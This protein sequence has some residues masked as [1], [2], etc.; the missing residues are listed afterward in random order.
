MEVDEAAGEYR[1]RYK[2]RERGRQLAMEQS[3][4]ETLHR[5]QHAAPHQQRHWAPGQWVYV[6]RRARANKGLHLRDRWVGPGIVV[7]SNNNTVYV[8]MRSR[9]WRCATEQLRPALSSEILGK[10]LT[11]DPGLA[12]LLRQVIAGTRA[13]A[14]DVAREGPPPATAR[15]GPVEH[16]PDGVQL[17][18]SNELRLPS[19]E[20][21]QHQAPQVVPAVPPGLLAPGLPPDAAAVRTPTPSPLAHEV[22]VPPDHPDDESE[23]RTSRRSSLQEPF[24]EPDA[25]AAEML[26][27]PGLESIVEEEEEVMSGGE[28]PEPPPKVP[29]LEISSSETSDPAISTSQAASSSTNPTDQVEPGTRA[30]GT[31]IRQLMDRVIR[32]QITPA[33]LLL[34]ENRVETLSEEFDE[35]TR[36]NVGW[37]G[38]YFNYSLGDQVL[39]PQPDGLWTLLAKRNDEISLK[40]LSMEER[41]LFE[42]SDKIEWEAILKTKAVRVVTGAEAEK[43]RKLYPDRIMSS[44]MVRRKK[45]QPGL[46]AWKAKSRWCIHG[47]CDPDTGTLVTYAPTPQSEG[48]MLFHQVALNHQMRFA[49]TDVRNAFCQS[50]P[51]RRPRGPLFAEPCEGLGLPPGSLICIDIPVYGLDDAPASWRM[52]VASFLVEDLGF[53]RNIVEPCWYSL[54]QEGQ[55]IA[56][57]LVEVD[58]FVI[59]AIPSYYPSLKK[60]M[61]ARF[62][63][64]K[65][66]ENSAEYAGRRI[67]CYDEFILVDQSKYIQEQVFPISLARGRRQQSGESLTAEEFTSLRSLIYKINWLA[68]ETRPE[69]AGLASIMASKLKSAR[70]GDILTVNKFV[71]FLRSTAERPLKIWR[72][73]P[74]DMCF[75]VCSDAGGINTK[76]AEILDEEG[77]PSDATQGAWMVLSAAHLPHGQQQVKAS[78]MA[79]RSSKLRRKV[80]STYGGETQAMLQGVNEVDWLQVMYRDA[81]AHDVQL[82]TWRSSL[83]PHMLV[84]RGQCELGGRQQQCSVTDAKSLF[85]CLLREHPTGKQDRKSALE[86]AIVLRDLQETKSM[87]R[88]VP[89]QKMIVDCLTHE[90]PL[91]AN[92]A[93]NQLLRTGILSLVDVAQ[94]LASRKLD[95]MYRRRSHAASRE[96]LLGKYRESFVQWT[97][98]LVNDI[99]G[100]CGKLTHEND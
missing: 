14:V 61:Q 31:P 26:E 84:M 71:N 92:D 51:L 9:L 46:H 90:D 80:F 1:R 59:A 27:P 63:F 33:E 24:S 39:T 47:H 19:G 74:M 37:S 6:Y 20:P 76:G 69:A 8:G 18:D 98:T 23:P 5:A 72:F 54:F 36:H 75:I 4:K 58:D 13:G 99:W 52:T 2:I 22:P 89:H 78:P 35:M 56:Q 43:I 95:P 42:E 50:N 64:G 25:S 66:E 49:F 83:S 100:S 53:E 55:C 7:L 68:R 48:L 29:R 93:L 28:V 38:S 44:R 67:R 12:S 86:L 87:V 34:P 15:V 16:Q 41:K 70:V 94:E 21:V 11:S 91:R 82:S 62:H 45:P 17:G 32:P 10:D 73:D 79:W 88:W 97:S 30:P 57:I 96:R 3:S 77:L 40:D 81:T 60:A 65:W 85:D